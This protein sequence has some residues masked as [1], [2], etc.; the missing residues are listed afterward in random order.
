MSPDSQISPTPRFVHAEDR[1]IGERRSL[2]YLC[3][4][5]SEDEMSA[6]L[7]AVDFAGDVRVLRA[8]EVGLVMLRGRT[9]GDGAPFNV[10][11]ATV[12]RAVVALASGETGYGYCLGR[13]ATRARL[14]AVIDAV[15]QHPE[16]GPRIRSSLAAI[17]G[18][19]LV[20]ENREINEQTAATRVN[21]FTLVRGED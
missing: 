3:A 4:R 5:A 19:R 15:G 6:A 12:T 13:A 18:P 2:M 16:L 11:E 20:A 7:R 21:F 8:P 1:K 17:V 10:G 14:A 9:G